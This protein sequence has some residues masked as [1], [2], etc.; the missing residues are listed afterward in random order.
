MVIAMYLDWVIE[1]EPGG[2][3]PFVSSALRE[4]KHK[5]HNQE[6]HI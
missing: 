2:S 4:V 6:A 1:Y 5:Q 3:N